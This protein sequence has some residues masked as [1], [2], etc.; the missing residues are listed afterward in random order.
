MLNDRGISLL[1]RHIVMSADVDV[2]S[3]ELTER[4]KV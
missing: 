2:K 1:A 4:R 3:V